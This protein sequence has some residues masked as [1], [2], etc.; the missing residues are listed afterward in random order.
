V[1]DVMLSMLA[2]AP[3]ASRVTGALLATIAAHGVLLAL[4]VGHRAVEPAPPVVSELAWVELAEPPPPPAPPAPVEAKAAAPTRAVR[5]S[6]AKPAAP[7]PAAAA[8]PL[9]TASETAPSSD[10]P[11]RFVTDPNGT[12]FGYG[13]V[14][15]GG[16]SQGQGGAGTVADAVGAEPRSH[17]V[18]PALSRA[19]SL[20]EH[21]PCRGYFPERAQ[22]DRGDVTLKVRIAA[23]G[24]VRGV[25]VTRE[26]P[27]GQGFGAAARECL[28]AKRFTPALDLSGQPTAVVSPITVRFAR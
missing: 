8:A 13:T 25:T 9:R 11:V 3:R 16:A 19:P 12:A 28:Q 1:N 14:Q 27:T 21:D 18:Q 10:E 4:G 23:D 6:S 7:A 15:R 26:L 17:E 20:G 5:K 2:P 24:A 22:V